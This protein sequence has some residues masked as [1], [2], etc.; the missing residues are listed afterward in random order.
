MRFNQS[1]LAFLATAGLVSAQT[2]TD[3]NPTLKT[4]PSDDGLDSSSFSSDFTK[5]SSAFSS[6]S[7]ASG[8]TINYGSKGAEFTITKEGEAPT[9]QTDFYFFFGTVEV[10]MQAAPGTGIVSSIVLESDDLDEIDWEFLGGDTTQVESNYF[11]KGNTTTYDRA[12]YYPVSSP[13]TT[14]HTYLIDWTSSR[15]IFSIDGV[16]VRTLNYQDADGGANYPQTP[17]RLKLGN[18]AGGASTEPAGTV[19]WAGGATDFGAAPFTMYVE[20]V[21]INNANPAKE[22]TYGDKTGSW[23]SIKIGEDSGASEASSGGSSSAVSSSAASSSAA[24]LSKTSASV[25]ATSASSA[26]PSHKVAANA[27]ASKVVSDSAS[28]ASAS[29]TSSAAQNDTASSSTEKSSSMHSTTK[30]SLPTA[31]AYSNSNGTSASGHSNSSATTS[32]GAVQHTTNDA[33]S[34][35][36]SMAVLSVFTLAMCFWML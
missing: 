21:K 17:M 30:T 23:Q 19:E 27:A 25:S 2:S 26:V 11:G 34:H 36:G 8:T 16:A 3:C 12:I 14:M 7:A 20:S 1:T 18:W 4:C 22:Y 5:G 33:Q 10:I 15:L 31:A 24:A 28:A 6:W 32:A 9:V 13:Q 29:A 35:T